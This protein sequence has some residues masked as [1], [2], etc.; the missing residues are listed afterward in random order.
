M[1]TNISNYAPALRHLMI[2]LLGLGLGFQ[3]AAE[4]VFQAHLSTSGGNAQLNFGRIY[5][6]A[7]GNQVDFM[8]VIFPFGSLT[9]NLNPVLTVP[10]D[11]FNFSFGAGTRTWLHGTHTVADQNPFLPAPP[12]RP[13][14]YD[15]NGTPLYVDAA[16]IRL[17]DIYTG[18]FTLPDG[19][20]D[21]LLAGLGQISFNSSLGGIITVA[22]VPEPT[23][24]TLL[25]LA[26]W[27]WGL[28][29]RLGRGAG[30]Q[31]PPAPRLD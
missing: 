3:A 23:T 30:F 7:E 12:W 16:V 26:G 14:S 29:R 21:D 6:R 19:F 28:R 2:G 13:H 31:S 11:S 10:G 9:D 8:A 17:T 22:T 4:N 24:G 5:L 18:Q 25:L 20:A 1:K 27:G 15:E